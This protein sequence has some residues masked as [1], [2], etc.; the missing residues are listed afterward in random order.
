MLWYSVLFGYRFFPFLSVLL[1]E[2][3]GFCFDGGFPIQIL[4]N[5]KRTIDL[6]G[7]FDTI[8]DPSAKNEWKFINQVPFCNHR[9]TSATFEDCQR[10]SLY[11][12][13]SG[14]SQH[15][16]GTLSFIR[17]LSKTIW[18]HRD[19]FEVFCKTLPFLY[20]NFKSY[21][22]KKCTICSPSTTFSVFQTQSVPI[23]NFRSF[24]ATLIS[25]IGILPA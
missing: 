6:P 2:G 17:G 16:S 19:I 9:D 3:W 8:R 4:V 15:T 11:P 13:T 12:S 22:M 25:T 14:P 21:L 1:H 23:N 7:P 5:W 18:T 24:V 10:P 20:D